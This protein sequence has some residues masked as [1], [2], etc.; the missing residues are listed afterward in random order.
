MTLHQFPQVYGGTGLLG[1]SLRRGPTVLFHATFTAPNDTPLADYV[2]DIDVSGLGFVAITGS[3]NFT[4][5][6]NRLLIS[7]SAPSHVANVLTGDYRADVITNRIGGGATGLAFRVQDVSNFFLCG[8]GNNL[9]ALFQCVSGTFFLRA[10]VAVTSPANQDVP[11]FVEL[12]GTLITFGGGQGAG[13]S[14]T[15]TSSTHQAES[16]IALR[17]R[18]PNDKIDDFTVTP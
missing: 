17:G 9:V 10:S 2:P 4:I 11:I 14:N 13:G 15:Y 3:Q 1:A 6:S 16:K 7:N 8:A 18:D 12:R 5:Q